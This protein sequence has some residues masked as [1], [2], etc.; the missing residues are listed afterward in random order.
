M[1]SPATFDSF[2][3]YKTTFKTSTITGMFCSVR[4]VGIAL[5][6]T[7]SVAISV[8][9]TKCK[10]HGPPLRRSD[11]R[12]NTPGNRQRSHPLFCPSRFLIHGYPSTLARF[13]IGHY[14]HSF[15]LKGLAHRLISTQN[16]HKHQIVV[17]PT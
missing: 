9:V 12:S 7:S 13:N 10:I 1:T 17:N 4:A 6:V 11:R 8:D 15:Y 16:K 5:Q 14:A 2:F 3:F